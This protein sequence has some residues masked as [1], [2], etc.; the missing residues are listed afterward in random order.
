M[1]RKNHK[2]EF[3]TRK[4]RQEG[5]PARSVYK[6]KEIDEKYRLFKKGDHVLDL[7]A[8]PGSW[9]LYV[10]KKVGKNGKVVGI[11][12]E[13]IKIKKEENMVFIKRDVM[14]LKDSEIDLL[15]KKYQIVI[16]DLAPATSGIKI[17]DTERSLE[18]CEKTLEIAKGVLL[19]KGNFVCKIFEGKEVEKFFKKIEENFELA[20]R[21]RPKSV[22]KGSRE[23]YIVAKFFKYG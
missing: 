4:S 14:E 3:Y 10:S 5:Y 21:F 9:F 1:Y 13:D 11:D 23:L 8:A 20:K 17:L 16:S 22:Y 12:Q 6:L 19:P 7:G 15:K 18:L 2:N